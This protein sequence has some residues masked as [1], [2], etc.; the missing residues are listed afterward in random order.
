[1]KTLHIFTTDQGGAAKAAIRLHLGLKSIGVQSKMLTL[2]RTSSDTDIVPYITNN[3]I[4]KRA[5][6]KIRNRLVS[7]EFNVYKN[8]RLKGLDIFTDDKSIYAV[9]KHPLIE[10]ANIIH[11]H[12]IAGM[13]NYTEFFPNV[14]NKPIIWTLHDSNPF[15][16][17]CHVPGECTKYE[18]GCGSCPQS[19]SKDPNDLPGRIFKRK[20]KAYKDGNIHL[21]TPS[22]WLRDCAKR[23]LL[24]KKFP[25]DIIPNAVPT[26]VFIKRNKQLSRD[27]LNLPQDKTLILFGAAY[28]TENKGFS[29]LSKSLKILNSKMDTSK[30]ALVA[31]GPKQDLVR[32]SKNVEFPIH[33]LGYIKDETLLSSVYSAAD[34]FIMSS[35]WENFSNV[36]LES[37]ACA[38]PVI[39]FNAGGTSDMI[40]PYE[41]GLIA[42]PK[43]TQNLA[44]KIEYMITHL[45]ERQEMG[46]NARK[47]VEQEYTLQTQAKRYLNLYKKILKP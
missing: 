46:K 34:I 23:S 47:L 18:T 13:V 9:S 15:T 5:W 1:M 27:L 20:G 11:L 6:N 35:L 21:V 42:E 12:W 24:F 45:K 14:M 7:F 19:G 26:S 30:I 28:K 31:F 16:G 3:N 38:I 40:K 39:G 32:L 43:N 2:P 41:T 37:F 22:K 44:D 29:Y 8:T 4:V 36:I 10:E 17:G 25:I 33:Q